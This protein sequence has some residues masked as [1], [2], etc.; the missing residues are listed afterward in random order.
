MA[1][2]AR[3]WM[4]TGGT[5]QAFITGPGS[6]FV[7]VT[8]PRYH[9][10]DPV[11]NDRDKK[12]LDLA[13]KMLNDDWVRGIRDTD[14]KTIKMAWRKADQKI[15]WVSEEMYTTHWLDMEIRN[16]KPHYPNSKHGSDN[17]ESRLVE[18]VAAGYRVRDTWNNPGDRV[19]RFDVY[20]RGKKIDS[21]S[22]QHNMSEKDVKDGLINHDG[23]DSGISLREV[24]TADR[25][26]AFGQGLPEMTDVDWKRLEQSNREQH[27]LWQRDKEKFRKM[28]QKEY[29]DE[30][31]EYLDRAKKIKNRNVNYYDQMEQLKQLK[32]L[33]DFGDF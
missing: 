3:P 28:Q 32:A 24:K 30:D 22:V 11:V 14:E 10:D 21:V 13:V 27:L 9:R 31:R 29:D 23:Y 12:C 33:G 6:A 5:V 7:G 1:S 25:A 2:S 19:R 8:T 16:G 18:R 26:A 20:L 4:W 17:R 15:P